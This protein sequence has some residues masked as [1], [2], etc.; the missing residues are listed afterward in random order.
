MS[1]LIPYIKHYPE[2]LGLLSNPPR[3]CDPSQNGFLFDSPHLQ[4]YTFPLFG[5]S[6][7]SESYNWK[8]PLTSNG[9]LS[10]IFI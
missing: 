9:P 1:S 7:P 5:Y 10:E 4:R 6:F 8:S 2:T 3:L